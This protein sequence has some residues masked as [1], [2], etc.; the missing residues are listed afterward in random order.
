MHELQCILLFYSNN[1]KLSYDEMMHSTQDIP[2]FE[3]FSY[4]CMFSNRCTHE[5]VTT[6][7]DVCELVVTDQIPQCYPVG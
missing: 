6:S 4:T 1:L 7:I 3:E 5:W 2:V